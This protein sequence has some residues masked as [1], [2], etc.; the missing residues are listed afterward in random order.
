VHGSIGASE[1]EAR[2]E[3]ASVGE[4]EGAALT[5]CAA[6]NAIPNAAQDQTASDRFSIPQRNEAWE[7]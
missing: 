4:G 3:D 5:Q 1:A 7:K 6:E 2:F